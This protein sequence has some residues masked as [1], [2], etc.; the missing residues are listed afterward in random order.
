MSLAFVFDPKSNVA[1]IYIGSASNSYSVDKSHINFDRIKELFTQY[2]S[3]D[4]NEQDAIE[5]EL[6]TLVNIPKTIEN[7]SCGSLEVRGDEI[8][9]NGVPLHN[10]LVDRIFEV[11]KSGFP[12]QHLLKFLENI[13]LN[14]SYRAINELYG[15][16]EHKGLPITSDGHFLAYKAVTGNFKDKHTNTFDNTVGKTVSMKR[17]EVDDDCS[18]GCSK[19]LHAG[20]L[21]YVNG[22]RSY[23]DKTVVVKINPKD[24]VSVP[25]DSNEE[26]V[27]V[28]EY[29]VV[30]V[31]Q[32]EFIAPVV[33][34]YD[35][36]DDEEDYDG[37]DCDDGV[38]D[39]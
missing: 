23:D 24:V 11:M 16:L 13:M 8:Y 3:A 14:P 19:G 35:D 26:K 10:V 4:N 38:Y 21:D 27:R 25:K 1:T 37:N 31:L 20:T 2:Y 29:A 6:T 32:S 34:E 15:F 33:E 36:D 30:D 7:Q 12:V 28:C 39:G 18:I 22:F 9:H 5:A 17:T